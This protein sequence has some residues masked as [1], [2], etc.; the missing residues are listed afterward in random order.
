[1][2]KAIASAAH[3]NATDLELIEDAYTHSKTRI[4]ESLA[5]NVQKSLGL[6]IEPQVA[7][8]LLLANFI[9]G[10]SPESKQEVFL[11]NRDDLESPIPREE[12]KKHL[13][14]QGVGSMT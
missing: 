13:P 4:R 6:R 1:M 11:K 7:L 3:S 9:L 14:T 12:C 8:R 2:R 10:W 5:A